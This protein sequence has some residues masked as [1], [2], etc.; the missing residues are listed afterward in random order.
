VFD[1]GE[2]VEVRVDADGD[3]GNGY[4]LV[5]ATLNTADTITLGADVVLG[6]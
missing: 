1:D 4:E 6:S 2:N 5:V 3:A